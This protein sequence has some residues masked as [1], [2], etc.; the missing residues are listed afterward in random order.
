MRSGRSEQQAR[1]VHGVHRPWPRALVR[2]AL[3][4]LTLLACGPEDDADLRG[5][6]DEIYDLTFV[7][8]RARLDNSG[9]SIQ[10]IAGDGQVPVEVRVRRPPDGPA[11]ID[12]AQDGDVL[13]SRDGMPLP[14]RRRGVLALTAFATEDGAAVIGHFEALLSAGERSYTLEG[15]F[16]TVLE[17]RRPPGRR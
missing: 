9:L 15:R 6:V 14:A 10:Y 12:L 8:T 16:D 4:A 17:D 5:S 11:V 2:L 7:E 1:A 13:G 3:V